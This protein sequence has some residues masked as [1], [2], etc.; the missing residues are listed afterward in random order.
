MSKQI[1]SKSFKKEIT[2]KLFF[3]R[4]YMYIYSNVCKQTTDVKLPLLHSNTWNHFTM[5]KQMINSK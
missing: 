2:Y 3:N 5:C 1:S 4:L